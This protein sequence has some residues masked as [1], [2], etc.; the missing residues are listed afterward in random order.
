MGLPLGGI[1]MWGR[2]GS[3]F[4]V[5]GGQQ[6]V[7]CTWLQTP[8]A[9]K[10]IGPLGVK[11]LGE[12]LGKG[13]RWRSRALLGVHRGTLPGLAPLPMGTPVSGVCSGSAHLAIPTYACTFLLPACFLICS[14]GDP[15]P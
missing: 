7:L 1:A 5:G 13:M 6:G 3:L 4:W 15:D 14:V 2:K 8:S 12:E 10:K 9:S 11:E